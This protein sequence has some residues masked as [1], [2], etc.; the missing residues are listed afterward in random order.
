MPNRSLYE[1]LGGYDAIAA[2]AGAFLPRVTADDKLRRFWDHR[3]ADG[4]EREK[5]LLIDFLANA[6]GGPLF[7]SGRDMSAT[8]LGMNIDGEDYD[9]LVGHLGDTLDS[10]GVGDAEKSDVLGFVESLRAEIAE[11]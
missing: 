11:A 2:V 5:Q 1:R 6:S 8:H 10:F 7:Y 4:V 3:G 9:R